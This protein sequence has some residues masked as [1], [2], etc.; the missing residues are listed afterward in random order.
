MGDKV[1]VVDLS[2]GDE[3]LSTRR[4]SHEDMELVTRRRW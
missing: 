1:V 2:L 4:V 3:E